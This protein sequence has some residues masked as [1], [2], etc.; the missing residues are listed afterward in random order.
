M[1]TIEE[2]FKDTYPKLAKQLEEL[3]IKTTTQ[4]KE[5]FESNGKYVSE[6]LDYD[7]KDNEKIRSIA[8][9]PTPFNKKSTIGG[10]ITIS[11]IV[12]LPLYLLY[13]LIQWIVW[14]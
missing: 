12:A 5:R 14:Q 11:I 8:E 4:L 9:S 2:I 13:K 1:D 6:V 10:A 3:G 7:L